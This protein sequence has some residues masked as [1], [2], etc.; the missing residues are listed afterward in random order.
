MKKQT[1][2]LMIAGT[3]LAALA[4][5]VAPFGN[6]FAATTPTWPDTGSTA[7]IKR[8]INNAY[9]TVDVD[10]GYTITA[11]SGNPTGAT[12]AP[13]S[14]TISFD[15]SYATQTNA[16][17]TVNVSF[18][19]MQFSQVG[20][21]SYIIRETSSNV[22][23][24]PVDSTNYYTAII[25]V[26]NNASLTGYV[27]SLYL[28]DASGDKLDAITGNNSEVTFANG[29]TYTNIQVSATASGNAADPNKCFD[30][31]INFTGTTDSYAVSTS[32]TCGNASTV[33]NGD[34]I[35]LKAGDTV[36]IGVNGTNS[37]IPVGTAYTITKTDTT[38]GYTVS[39]DGNQVS[40]VSKT[41][42]AT[43]NSSF[44]TANKTTIDEYKNA[45]VVTNAFMNISI[46]VLLAIAGGVG[47]YFVAKK[48]S[49]KEA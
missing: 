44:N 23:T 25:S 31:R 7:T 46:Y 18:A 40:N 2:K 9:G 17:S 19:N 45:T 21:Y 36:T 13:T 32:S 27:A 41:M 12:G 49:K 35:K 42:V 29:A 48:K 22:S 33:S 38:D 10:F 24:F 14:T 26:R 4:T 11:D 20:D 39:M 8:T 3:T 1:N 30:Y 47:I 28:H 15:S 5:V 37:Q 43:N 6:A 34:T 16:T